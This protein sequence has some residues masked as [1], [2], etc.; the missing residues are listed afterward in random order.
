MVALA[1]ALGNVV[2]AEGV[3]G[4]TAA[5]LAERG[6]EVLAGESAVLTARQVDGWLRSDGGAE[7]PTAA[8]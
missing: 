5:W 4:S 1:R 6:C 3:D 2:L 7:R 8:E